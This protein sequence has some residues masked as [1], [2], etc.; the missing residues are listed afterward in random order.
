MKRVKIS[1]FVL[2]PIFFTGIN[3]LLIDGL[4]D[5]IRVSDVGIVLGSKV[6]PD[7]LPSDRLRARL[8]RTSDLYQQGMFKK[9][10]VSG[11]T[12]K[13]RYSEARVMADYL[14]S[15]KRVPRMPSFSMS[16]ETPHRP[17]RETAWCS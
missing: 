1:G 15:Q 17:P 11:G 16:T 12:G 3:A 8:D 9:I 4:T 5:D 14:S 7:G 6:M 2:L 10:I 13:E